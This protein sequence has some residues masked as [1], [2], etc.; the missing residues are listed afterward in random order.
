LGL[1]EKGEHNK[2]RRISDMPE[3]N[4]QFLYRYESYKY[5]D[6]GIEIKL[7]K[8]K[9]IRKT[10]CG[11]WIRMYNSSE[12][13]VLLRYSNGNK[14]RKQ[15]AYETEKEALKGFIHRKVRQMS[16]FRAR[17]RVAED[18]HDQAIELA[19]NKGYDFKF[20]KSNEIIWEY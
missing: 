1:Y 5:I 19:Q 6:Y 2:R 9:I 10:P 12:K 16:I 18:A 13:F 7:L 15:F 8:F 3:K 17:L 11:I 20:C 14:P 4:E